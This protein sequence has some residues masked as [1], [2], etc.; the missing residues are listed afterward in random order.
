MNTVNTKLSIAERIAA[1]KAQHA[2]PTQPTQPTQQSG[3]CGAL[4]AET[5]H[6]TANA[7]ENEQPTPQQPKAQQAQAQAHKIGNLIA[8]RI[9]A[10]KAVQRAAEA[11]KAE[12]TEPTEPKRTLT[13]AERLAILKAQQQAARGIPQPSIQAAAQQQTEAAQSTEAS[14]SQQPLSAYEAK[15]AAVAFNAEQQQAIAYATEGRSF[16]LIGA[17]GTGKTTAVREIVRQSLLNNAP[18]QVANTTLDS[19]ALVS[20]TNR[21]VNNLRTACEGIAD[22]DLRNRALRCCSTVHKLLQ[23]APVHYEVMRK[24][25]QGQD[26][27]ATT[28][29]FEPTF[30]CGNT[31]DH[32]KTIIVD[33]ASMLGLALYKQLMEACPNATVIFIGDLNQ[34][35]PVMDD[36]ILGYKLAELPVVELVTV[37]RQAMESPIVRFQHEFTLAGKMVGNT[38]LERISKESNGILHFQPINNPRTP[39]LLARV[40]ANA[41][42]KH[43]D[44]GIYVPCKDIILMPN[45]K[46]F[47]TH[48][49]NQWIAQELGKRRDALVYEINCNVHR[50]TGS[51]KRYYAVGDYVVHNKE[52][53]FIASIDANARYNG[54]QLQLPST[55]LNRTGS[56]DCNASAARGAELMDFDDVL[57][58]VTQDKDQKEICSHTLVLVPAQGCATLEEAQ[59]VGLEAIVIN[60]R[61]EVGELEFG[62]AL[63]VHKSQGSEWRK[64]FLALAIHARNM[65]SRELL[66]VGM[67][68][69]REELYIYYSPDSKAGAADNSIARCIR[70]QEIKGR[71]WKEKVV[72]FNAR[73][74]E[75]KA[76]MATQTQYGVFS[77]E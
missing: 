11:A 21:A 36:S 74:D 17:A 70:N 38:T 19:I 15:R 8:Q 73:Y 47:G 51:N 58:E 72:A 54:R 37:Y 66:Y 4:G 49:V 45:Y 13:I 10:A 42:M 50:L 20:F 61:S 34:L 29:R 64:V 18:K 48:L 5:P 65:L 25:A 52:E 59:Q 71:T 44:E 2:Q 68:R 3:V 53:Y 28:M 41:M 24:N 26:S 57:L 40:F 31:L 22:A 6:A 39:E 30:R 27:L 9:A 46:N 43:M 62:Y 1:M 12:P 55:K 77:D 32:I 7:T 23:F 16:C 14:Q 69:A 67:T 75:Y 33:E 63:T 76:F 35:K 60:T 56:L